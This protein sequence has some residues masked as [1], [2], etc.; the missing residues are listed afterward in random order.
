MLMM[1][2][3]CVT[4]EI[5][6]V[7]RPDNMGSLKNARADK[8]RAKAGAVDMCCCVGDFL[9]CLCGLGLSPM[10]RCAT[11][12]RASV[13]NTPW[14]THLLLLLLPYLHACPC[15]TANGRPVCATTE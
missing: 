1:L 11:N 13:H 12:K 15:L 3:K 4:N 8:R 2:C 9:S 7:L 10:R 14:D 5:K 6:K